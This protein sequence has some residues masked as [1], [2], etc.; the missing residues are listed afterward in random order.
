VYG[1][2]EL[3]K[4]ALSPSELT[5]NW[6]LLQQPHTHMIKSWFDRMDT[7]ASLLS[8]IQ[9]LSHLPYYQQCGKYH[10]ADMMTTGMGGMPMSMY[11]VEFFMYSVLASPLILGCDVRNLSSDYL[12]LLISPEVL[13]IQQDG[14]CV[15]GSQASAFDSGEVWIKPLSDGSFAVGLMNKGSRPLNMTVQIDR[16]VMWSDFYPADYYTEMYVR[17]VYLRVE[18]GLFNGTFTQEVPPYDAMIFQFTPAD[19]SNAENIVKN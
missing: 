19:S 13:D 17:D 7:W 10:T 2:E 15:Q 8:N 1:Q 16:S 4:V 14:Q 9:Q 18:L 12:E 5:W 11:R 3:R 6:G